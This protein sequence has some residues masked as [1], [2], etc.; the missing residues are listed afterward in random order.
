MWRTSSRWPRRGRF[1]DSQPYHRKEVDNEA[2]SPM[3]AYGPGY[4]DYIGYSDGSVSRASN[5]RTRGLSIRWRPPLHA[6][7]KTENSN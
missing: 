7:P 1:A 6:L 4:S 5:T 2:F 3:A